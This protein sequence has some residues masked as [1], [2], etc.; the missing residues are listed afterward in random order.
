LKD[1][2]QAAARSGI[3]IL[4]GSLGG[5]GGGGGVASLIGRFLG[6]GSG[7][8][9]VSPISTTPQFIGAPFTAHG[10]VFN[11]PQVRTIA[12]RGPEAVIPL[13]SGM[14]PVSFISPPDTQQRSSPVDVTIVNAPDK[15]S[16]ERL[17]SQKNAILNIITENIESGGVVHKTIK[18]TVSPV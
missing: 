7:G 9:G 12:E 18:R 4:F 16:G 8:G 10:G 15:S 3:N 17:A 2:A 6:I 1:I 5:D 14:V 11:V 13:Q